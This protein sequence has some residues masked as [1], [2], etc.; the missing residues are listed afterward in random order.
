M[1]R[2]W[3]WLAYA[4]VLAPTPA[5]AGAEPVSS[6]RIDYFLAD[7]GVE[8]TAYVSVSS[9]E[10]LIVRL[11]KICAK[12][13]KVWAVDSG[14]GYTCKSMTKHDGVNEWHYRVVLKINLKLDESI[15][16]SLFSVNKDSAQ[17][18]SQRPLTEEQRNRLIKIFSKNK[19]LYQGAIAAIEKNMGKAAPMKGVVA[20]L[21]PWHIENDEY[22]RNQVYLVAVQDN[23]VITIKGEMRGE[24]RGIYSIVG[25][26]YPAVQVSTDGDGVFEYLYPTESPA[27]PLVEISVH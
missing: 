7:T 27:N 20:Y 14:L 25:R 13:G 16:P 21:I 18:L 1:N 12:G 11:K 2:Y 10:S 19:T 5:L 17:R 26:K 8:L 6:S 4:F 22:G 24:I 9:P 3:I 23:E 15:Y